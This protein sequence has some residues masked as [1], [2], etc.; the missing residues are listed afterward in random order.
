MLTQHILQVKLLGGT[1]GWS[2]EQEAILVLM[3]LTEQ[4]IQKSACTRTMPFADTASGGMLC[5]RE[6]E[7][8][9]ARPGE[10]A[11]T[12]AHG[13]TRAGK[14]GAVSDSLT[15]G[16]PAPGARRVINKRL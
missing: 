4:T 10:T 5:R 6:V 16:F 14:V 11:W 9:H 12:R 2:H 15:A 1:Q 13:D 8:V 7:R 3:G